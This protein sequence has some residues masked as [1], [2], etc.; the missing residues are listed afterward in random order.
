MAREQGNP[1][2]G[3]AF[4]IAPCLARERPSLG[5]PP[6]ILGSA[7]LLEVR[8]AAS[9]GELRRAQRLRFR[10][11]FEEGGAV[12]DRTARSARR[13][14]CRFDRVCDHLIVVDKSAADSDGAPTVVGAYRLLRQEIAEAN[15]GFY[16]AREF[17]VDALLARHPGKRFLELGRSCVARDYRGRRT[18]ELLWR[19]IWGYASWHGVD[20]MFGCASFPGVDAGAHAT[21]MRFLRGERESEPMWRV[22]ARAS[23]A[24]FDGA[25]DD[26]PLDRREALRAMP[27]L[28]KGY[29]RLGARFSREAVVDP[30]FG[31][32]DLFVVLP[33]EEIEARYLAYFAPGREFPPIAA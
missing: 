10:V 9:A 12:A 29:W 24:V 1:A 17:Q 3:G 26:A 31:T 22:D 30:A 6:G 14:V 8:L 28:I 13:D 16:S 4:G 18:L 5:G 33:R 25:S 19:G 2:R 7:G 32:T 23:R 21:T 20:A 27:P 11:F 15:F